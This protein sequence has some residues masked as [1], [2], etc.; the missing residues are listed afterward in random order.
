[1]SSLQ[2]SNDTSYFIAVLHVGFGMWKPK[3]IHAHIKA[4]RFVAALDCSTHHC[5]I[6]RS[7]SY[8]L[9]LFCM[10]ARLLCAST[11]DVQEASCSATD[12]LSV[13]VLPAFSVPAT[14]SAHKLTAPG[15]RMEDSPTTDLKKVITNQHDSGVVDLARNVL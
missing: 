13:C 6:K 8:E 12:V 14:K 9:C 7:Q 1:M 4:S 2:L 15:K 10:Q 5:C 11:P 3:I